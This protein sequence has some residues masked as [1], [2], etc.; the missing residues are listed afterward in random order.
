MSQISKDESS[1][2]EKRK[3]ELEKEKQ[4]YTEVKATHDKQVKDLFENI[5]TL[6][7]VKELRYFK[8]QWQE[9]KSEKERKKIAAEMANATKGW[10]GDG[11]TI[12]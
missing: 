8:S 11:E 4:K 9:Q 7:F 2:A 12:E 5:G 10:V 3:G 1:L 6:K